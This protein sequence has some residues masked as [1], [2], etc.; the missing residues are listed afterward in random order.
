MRGLIL[1]AFLLFAGHAYASCPATSADC[2]SPI[3][4]NITAGGTLTVGGAFSAGTISGSLV[5]TATPTG[6]S[7]ARLIPDILADETNVLGYVGV[8]RTGTTDSSTGIQNAITVACASPVKSLFF[9]PGIYKLSTNLSV[10]ACTGLMLRAIPGT[11]TL[12]ADAT[13]AA[14]PARLLRVIRQS[15]LTVYGLTFDGNSSGSTASNNVLINVVGPSDHITLDSIVCQNAVSSCITAGNIPGINGTL[16]AQANAGTNT[17]TFSSTPTGLQAGAYFYG[18]QVDPEVYVT[19]TDATTATLSQNLTDTLLN[20][21]SQHWTFAFTL[22]G[23]AVGGATTLPTSSTTNLIVGQAIQYPGFCIVPGTKITAVTT[24]T[25]VT[26]DTPTTCKV[27]SGTN[28]AAMAGVSD[29]V[30]KNSTFLNPGISQRTLGSATFTTSGSTAS[31]ATQIVFSCVSASC[32]PGVGAI[33]GDLTAAAG[34]PAGMPASDLVVDGPSVNTGA[35][36]FTVTFASPTTGTIAGGTSIPFVVGA[37]SGNGFGIWL[38]Q[39]AWFANRNILFDNNVF[40]HAWSSPIFINNATN[41]LLQGNTYREDYLEYQNTTVA[42]SACIAPQNTINMRVVG[43]LCSG[44][45]GNGLEGDH[46]VGLQ[47]EGSTFNN[48]GRAGV[49]LCGGHDIRISGTFRNNAQWVNHPTIQ[50]YTSLVHGGIILDGSCTG[51]QAATISNVVIGT[52]NASDD[53]ATPTQP[54]GIAKGRSQGTVANL[55]IGINSVTAVGNTT[56][57]IGLTPV[58]SACGSGSPALSA[59]ATDFSGTITEGTSATGCVLTFGATK[60]VAPVCSVSSPGAAAFTSFST[61]TTALTIVNSSASG[62]QYNYVC[63]F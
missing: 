21:S 44:A 23:D 26:I 20:G 29:F 33:P 54:W 2:P 31:N 16:T 30:V 11:A 34:M 48:N 57:A 45:T 49:Y 39:S 15:Y 1:L 19:A 62:N 3:F 37:A 61:S 42:P 60:A 18:S 40:T 58:L 32:S 25:S 27:A 55:S 12:I 43:E 14:S 52:V 4:N 9:P 24:N 35:G 36:T 28:I 5:A 22:S 10:T 51:T 53:Q 46:N 6:G 13:T 17:L 38:G 56:G 63:T 41:L 47:I 50:Q 59:S 8:D 7:A